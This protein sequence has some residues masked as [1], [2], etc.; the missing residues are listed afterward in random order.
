MLQQ[1]KVY[2]TLQEMLALVETLRGAVYVQQQLFGLDTI[3]VIHSFLSSTQNW[4][5]CKKDKSCMY[6]ALLILQPLVIQGAF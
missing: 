5:S 6:C 3:Q 2:Q 1:L 4:L